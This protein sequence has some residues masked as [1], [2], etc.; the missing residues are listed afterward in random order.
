MMKHTLC[1]FIWFCLAYNHQA[2]ATEANQHH[3]PQSFSAANRHSAQGIHE[4]ELYSQAKHEPNPAKRALKL[5]SFIMQYPN[6]SLV[7]GAFESFE[8]SLKLY[9]Q[10]DHPAYRPFDE[11]GPAARLKGTQGD[12][13]SFAMASLWA[14]VDAFVIGPTAPTVKEHC[15]QTQRSIEAISIFHMPLGTSK[16]QYGK[17]RNHLAASI[18]GMAGFCEFTKSNYLTARDY[19]LKALPLEPDNLQNLSEVGMS[20][21]LMDPIDPAG[22]WYLARAETLSSKYPYWTSNGDI[23]TEGIQSIPDTFPALEMAYSRYHG[24]LE[25]WHEIKK[26]AATHTAPPDGFTIIKR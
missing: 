6:S 11:P 1:L 10:P 16:E 25:G 12:A 14:R 3:A 26:H 19:Y 23:P 21:F 17:L 5:E 2:F 7:L 20:C 15:A 22:F 24:S 4:Y 13:L 8:E 9:F 18:Y